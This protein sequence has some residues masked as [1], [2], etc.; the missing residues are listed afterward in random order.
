MVQT[1]YDKRYRTSLS[2]VRVGGTRHAHMSSQ[3]M[4]QVNLVFCVRYLFLKPKRVTLTQL[5]HH[6]L[7]LREK[8]TVRE[9]I[10]NRSLCSMEIKHIK[11]RDGTIQNFDIKKV[12]H[13]ILMALQETHSGTSV[14][15]SKV[16]A[17]RCAASFESCHNCCI[18]PRRSRTRR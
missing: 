4:S 13:A 11:K 9:S 15:A 17:S 14:D 12:E 18:V 3:L 6:R 10:I 2:T 16:A 1:L 8:I 5:P 7:C